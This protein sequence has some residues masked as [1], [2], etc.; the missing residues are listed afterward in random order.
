MTRPTRR[1]GWELGITR[2]RPFGKP[3]SADALEELDGLGPSV[4]DEVQGL[5]RGRYGNTA[6][7]HEEREDD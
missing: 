1:R 6:R 5:R 2:I 7:L 4:D 3:A